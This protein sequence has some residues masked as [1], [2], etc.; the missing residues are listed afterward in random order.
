MVTAAL[1][2]GWRPDVVVVEPEAVE[3]VQRTLN[4][5]AQTSVVYL[6]S[7]GLIRRTMVQPRLEALVAEGSP[8]G[9]PLTPV[10]DSGPALVLCCQDPN[11]TGTIIRTAVAFGMLAVVI[12]FKPPFAHIN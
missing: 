9:R 8:P 12:E 10:A 5:T 11:N 3:S 6:A 1:A 2:A 7:P 4:R